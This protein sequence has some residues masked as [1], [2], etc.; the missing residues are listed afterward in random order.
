[1][2]KQEFFQRMDDLGLA[3]TY[4]D[5]RLKTGYAE[6]MPN[7][8]SLETKFSRHISLKI[9]LISAAM[10][11]VTEYLMAIE[12]ARWGGIGV[13]HRNLSAE[14]QAMHVAR[15]KHH[16]NGRIEKPICVQIDD[17]IEQILAKREAKQYSFHTFPVLDMEYRLVGILTQNDFDFCADKTRSAQQ[18]MTPQLITASQ[19]T[20]IQQAYDLM[21]QEK[22]KVLPLVDNENHLAGMYIF[23]DVQRIISGVSSNYN[24]DEMGRLRVAAAIG[25]GEEALQRVELLYNENIDVVVIDTAH[26]DSQPVIETLQKLKKKYPNLDIVVGNISEASSAKRLLDAGADGLK[27]GQGPGSIC[28]TRIIAGIGC[29]QVT[30]I[31]HCAQITEKT[32]VPLCADG[33]LRYSGDISIALGAGAS[34]VMMGSM[35]AGTTQAPGEIIHHEGRAWKSY[36]GMGSL[37]AMQAHAGS[38]ERYKVEKER[39][40]PEGV[41]GIVP[42]KGALADVLQLNLGGLR[43]G[44]GYV[45]AATI[46]ELQTKADF[47]RI[48]TAGKEESHPHDIHMTR[49]QPNYKR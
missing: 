1:M 36:R 7:Q 9:P 5:V 22:K 39:L 3:L 44:M 28:T 35:L 26:A 13:I 27:I 6:L 29:P 8:V 49:D 42:Y 23:S 10:D 48:T 31:Y 25:T 2:G 14:E 40:I 32:D 4:D 38:R 33:G 34:T 11:T 19:Q 15:V 16:L 43:A 46:P 21:C 18:I 12:M 20:T 47:M 37:G 45:G 24:V 41:E 17:T 30:A